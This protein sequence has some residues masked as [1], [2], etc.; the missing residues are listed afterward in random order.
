VI[1]DSDLLSL[2]INSGRGGAG[3]ATSDRLMGF[4]PIALYAGGS[5]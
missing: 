4:G 1:L 5:G 2:A 3:G